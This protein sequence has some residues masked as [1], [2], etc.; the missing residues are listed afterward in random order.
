MCV[1]GITFANACE[2]RCAGYCGANPGVCS[3]GDACKPEPDLQVEPVCGSDGV[4]YQ[5]AQSALCLAGVWKTSPGP[6]NRKRSITY[7]S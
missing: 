7:H 4:T 1:G 5:N 6:C 2:S 3:P